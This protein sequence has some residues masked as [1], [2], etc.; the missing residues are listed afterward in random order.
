MHRFPVLLA[1]AA[2]ALS[3]VTAGAA[4]QSTSVLLPVHGSE[5]SAGPVFAGDGVA[6]VAGDHVLR[7]DAAGTIRQVDRWRWRDEP[8]GTGIAASGG[9]LAVT[10]TEQRCIE[11]DCRFNDKGPIRGELRTGPPDGPLSPA[12]ACVTARP[13]VSGDVLG[14]VCPNGVVVGPERRTFGAGPGADFG[15]PGALEHPYVAFTEQRSG[16][17]HVVVADWRTGEEVLAVAQPAAVGAL[18]VAADGT[19]VFVARGDRRVRV[20][21]PA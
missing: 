11:T 6:W 3:L 1:A 20:A 16:V 9:A 5:L 17:H 19:V 13:L 15:R 4:A 10:R 7:R 21:S 18:D 14:V 8:G 2:L 12:A